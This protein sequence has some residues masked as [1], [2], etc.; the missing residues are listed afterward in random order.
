MLHE[1]RHARDASRPATG[2]SPL[3]EATT[4]K[5]LAAMMEGTPRRSPFPSLTLVG[6]PRFRPFRN[7]W[8]LE[9][10][11]DALPAEVGFRY[12]HTV[13][14]PQS[15]EARAHHPMGKVPSLLVR[16]GTEGD[17]TLIESAA[18]NS[19][20]GDRMREYV[21]GGD[22][23]FL[24]PLP[25]SRDRA[26]YDSFVQFL[27]AEADSSG[28][29]IHRKLESL[30][31]K[32]A[33]GAVRYALLPARLQFDRAM[34][35]EDMCMGL[36]PVV[37][38]HAHAHAHVTC[39]CGYSLWHSGYSLYCIYI[40]L[41]ACVRSSKRRARGN[42]ATS[43]WAAASQRPT[44]CSCTAGSEE[45]PRP[46]HDG[47]HPPPAFHG[48]P[49]LGCSRR[50]TSRAAAPCMP[51]TCGPATLSLSRPG[52]L[53]RLGGRHRRRQGPSRL[54]VLQVCGRRRVP[55][56]LGP[57]ARATRVPA[58]QANPGG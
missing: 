6:T 29:W 47:Y 25:G 36:Q 43:S 41:Q 57:H 17:F 38:A 19:W 21:V 1:R 35:G 37:H 23:G 16:D 3:D 48:R 45:L 33:F 56:L 52:A 4:E 8:M 27:V 55:G 10:L 39:A 2:S 49:L 54:L 32:K 30:G 13:A 11:R 22:S 9:E 34:A 44:C 50:R 53:L 26:I 51:V 18:I 31:E 46:A 12:D 42:P 5:L 7:V 28:L 15:D 14:A 58:S 40:W 24:V 20:L